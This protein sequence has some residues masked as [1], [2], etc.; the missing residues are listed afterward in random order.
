MRKIL[1]FFC[2]LLFYTVYPQDYSP[3]KG[4]DDLLWGISLNASLKVNNSVSLTRTYVERELNSSPGFAVA[5]EYAPL[6]TDQFSAGGGIEY[7]FNNKVSGI[8]GSFQN[9]PFYLFYDFSITRIKY[10]NLPNIHFQ[11]GY[12]L[13]QVKDGF[14]S[15]NSK[16]E[17]GLYYAFGVSSKIISHLYARV[18]YTYYY[19]KLIYDNSGYL[20]NNRKISLTLFIR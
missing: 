14:V 9:I 3:R 5:I 15:P 19:G 10:I 11:A 16:A 13:L 12:N 1:L 4:S 20:Y 17:S 7:E 2:S 18:L 8:N 6:K